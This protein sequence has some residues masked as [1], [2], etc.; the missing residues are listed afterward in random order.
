MSLFAGERET[1]GPTIIVDDGTQ[2]NAAGTQAPLLVKS[3]T[4]T[5]IF[6]LTNTGVFSPTTIAVTNADGL[7]VNGVIV[8]QEEYIS[9]PLSATMPDADIAVINRAIKI[10]RVDLTISVQG[11]TG[12]AIDVRKITDTSAPG[13]A[14]SSTVKEFF[15]TPGQDLHSLTIN[16][17]TNVPLSATAADITLAAG[18]RIAINMSGTLTGLVG[19]VTITFVRV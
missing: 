18:N 8:P 6:S 12:A 11:G 17:V 2:K 3:A 19:Q 1:L 9:W 5:E 10:T 16:T 15:A 13:A 7:T 14:A 4:G